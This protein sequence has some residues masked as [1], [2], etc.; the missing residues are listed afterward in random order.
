M[1]AF[2]LTEGRVAP[3]LVRFALPFMLSSLLQSLYGAADLFVVGRY[4]GAA[5]VS[6]VSIGSQIMSTVTMLILSL[7]MGGTVLI[8]NCIGRRDHEGAAT[9]IG[10]Q[11]V[12]FGLFAVVLTP[13]M[14]LGTDAGVALMQTPA[15]A[16]ADARDY[17]FTCS[18]GLPFIVGYNALS[19]IFRGLGDSKTPVYFVALA[20]L[21]NIAADFLLVGWLKMGAT[22]AAIATIAAQGLSFAAALLWM[23]KTGFSFPF[24]KKHL[25][26]HG[27]SARRI[28]KVGAPLALQSTSVHLSFLIITAIINTM[29]LIASAAVGVTEK[30][31][32][33]AFLP[34]DAFAAAVAAMT[35]QNIGAGKPQRAL[36]AL[37]WSILFSLAF[38]FAVCG[39]ANL[40][41]EVL[42]A[43][44][45][46]DGQVIRAAGL[47]MRTYSVDCVLVAFVFSFNNY[48]S[49]CGNAVISMVHNIIATFA[50]RIPVTLLMS[51]VEGASLLHMGLAAPAAS[52]LSILICAGYFLRL[53][54]KSG[55]PV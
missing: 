13:L 37:K 12:L 27:P 21:I 8:G 42:P 53:R 34:P 3:T 1:K 46:T 43:I 36:Q 41:P 40:W 6:G 4:A 48:F 26:L 49:G 30:I 9:A 17:V 54:K 55:T 32:A 50:V 45:T 16:V 18:L 11:A 52:L 7:S 10:T 14:L 5:A 47:Y 35:A 20:T 51:R 22:G 39:F 15:E 23:C 25:R 29:G 28:L 38:G 2:S 33:F 44:F 31:M 19:G 24:T